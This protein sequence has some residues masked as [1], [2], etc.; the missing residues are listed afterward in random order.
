MWRVAVF[1]IFWSQAGCCS[2]NKILQRGSLFRVHRDGPGVYPATDSQW[3]LTRG[4][5]GSLPTW[6]LRFFISTGATE[7]FQFIYWSGYERHG[8]TSM[9]E[10]HLGHKPN[11]CT[12]LERRSSSSYNFT[13]R[14]WAYQ[15]SSYGVRLG[16]IM[17]AVKLLN[18]FSTSGAHCHPHADALVADKSDM[19]GPNVRRKSLYTTKSNEWQEL[20]NWVLGISDAASPLVL[21]ILK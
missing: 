2:A 16:S 20:L 15:F 14:F 12:G 5:A 11:S 13:L 21:C 7:T 10:A 6:V 8:L 4:S 18:V 3:I 19:D 9:N 17:S 1:W